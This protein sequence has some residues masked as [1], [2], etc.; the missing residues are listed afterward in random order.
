MRKLPLPVVF[1]L[2]AVGIGYALAANGRLSLA[3]SLRGTIVPP[4][5]P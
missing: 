3:Q 5:V 1:E 4:L 2:L